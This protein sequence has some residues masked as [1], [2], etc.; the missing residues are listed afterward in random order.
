[1]SFKV[2]EFLNDTL[3]QRLRWADNPGVSEPKSRAKSS[4]VDATATTGFRGRILLKGSFPTA[5]SA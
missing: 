5:R 1:M 2:S 3:R 4:Y